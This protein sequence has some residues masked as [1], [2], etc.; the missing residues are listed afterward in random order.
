MGLWGTSDSSSPRSTPPPRRNNSGSQPSPRNTPTAGFRSAYQ[1][2]VRRKLS[3]MGG[4][5]AHENRRTRA[6]EAARRAAAEIA[7]RI[8]RLT[9]RQPADST[10]RRN[11]SRDTAPTGVDPEWLHRQAHIDTAGGIAKFAALLG[12]SEY[13]TRTWRDTGRPLIPHSTD[14]NADV[15]GIL[16][17]NG[18]EYPRSMTVVLTLQPGPEADEIRIAYAHS[19]LDTIAELLGPLI[20]EEVD[21]AGEADRT[22]EVTD[23]SRI[24]VS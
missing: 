9:G 12:V 19:D 17:V 22:Y 3:E 6:A 7:R 10:I 18:E 16:W 13:A 20:A 2:L 1:A 8:G 11:A 24:T 23:I 21:W 15:E 5:W 14:V 4:H